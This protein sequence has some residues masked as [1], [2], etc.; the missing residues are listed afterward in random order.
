MSKEIMR[1]FIE[2]NKKYHT[3]IIIVTHNPIIADLATMVIHVAN[4]T[5]AKI[6]KNSHPKTVDDLDWT[7]I[8][9]KN[10]K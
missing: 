5:I 6:D 2:I 10:K 1:L 3:T 4:G 9:S 7:A 8:G